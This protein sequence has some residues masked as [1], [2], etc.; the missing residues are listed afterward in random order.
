MTDRPQGGKI[1]VATDG[2][3]SAERA[4]AAAAQKARALLFIGR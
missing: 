1:L 2:S 3:K 4:V